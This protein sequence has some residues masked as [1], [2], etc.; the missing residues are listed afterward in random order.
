MIRKVKSHG[1]SP[2]FSFS[3]FSYLFHL[4]STSIIS[5]Q[6]QDHSLCL[7][8]LVCN[9]CLCFHPYALACCRREPK[10]YETSPP[11]PFDFD[12][13]AVHFYLVFSPR[14]LSLGGAEKQHYW[15]NVSGMKSTIYITTTKT[16]TRW[17]LEK[18]HLLDRRLFHKILSLLQ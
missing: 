4:S 15:R 18:I 5:P 16:R 11:F 2:I 9:V 10:R 14:S 17:A 3:P 6:I 7:D 12:T 13:H 1:N 8:I